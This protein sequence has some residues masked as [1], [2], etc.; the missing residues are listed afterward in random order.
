MASFK[1]I[2]EHSKLACMCNGERSE[3]RSRAYYGHVFRILA[4]RICLN[5]FI[6]GDQWWTDYQPVS[7]T[8]TSKRGDRA[9]YQNMIETCHAAGV[10]VIAGVSNS[11]HQI[12]VVDNIRIDT[13]WN[14]MSGADSGK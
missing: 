1:V 9:Q 4:I 7:Y 8:L 3:S 12:F 6:S 10:K 2:N 11:H 5:I 13:I 14:H